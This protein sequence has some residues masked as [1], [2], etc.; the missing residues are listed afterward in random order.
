[1]KAAASPASSPATCSQAHRAGTEF[2]R[3][4]AMQEQAAPYDLVITSNAGYPLDMNL[5]QAVKGMRAAE[6]IVRDGGAIIIAAECSEGIPHGSP[7]DRLLRSV[8]RVEEILER[9]REP[10]FAWPE[11]WQSQIQALIQ[12]R[13]QVFLY[14]SLSDEETRAAHLTPCRDI[15]A[16]VQAP[17]AEWRSASRCC[18]KGRSPC[19]I[20]TP[21]DR[22]A[23]ASGST[24]SNSAKCSGRSGSEMRYSSP[25]H[26]PRSTMLA[27]RGAERARRA[28]RGKLAGFPQIGQGRSVLR[29]GMA[30]P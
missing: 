26:W 23:P 21:P 30:E 11:Q 12:R 3:A 2:V 9:V 14:S 18:R 24:F 8:S 22:A 20:F 6:G 29:V 15:A 5:Y 25:N 1:M 4:S 28:P 7:H 27:A 17:R 16:L 13:A 19:L 10:G